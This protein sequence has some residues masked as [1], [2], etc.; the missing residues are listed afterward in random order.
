MGQSVDLHNQTVNINELMT[1]GWDCTSG[2]GN[3]TETSV[4]AGD[5][6]ARVVLVTLAQIAA[7]CPKA[8]LVL[9]MSAGL[10]MTDRAIADKLGVALTTIY[11][12]KQR[13]RRVVPA[14]AAAMP[15]R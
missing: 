15:K 10:N 13:L 8:C 3:V 2:S 5:L 12:H 4:D 14:L 1:G 9:L 11:T 7:K 6:D